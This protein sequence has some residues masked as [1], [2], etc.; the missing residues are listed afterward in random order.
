MGV[1]SSI[2]LLNE[3]A[4][5][6]ASAHARHVN[7]EPEDEAIFWSLTLDYTHTLACRWCRNQHDLDPSEIATETIHHVVR[8]FPGCLALK[9][10]CYSTWLFAVTRNK[11]VDR[12]RSRRGQ[13]VPLDTVR[14]TPAAEPSPEQAAMIRELNDIVASLSSDE[15]T[16]VLQV[17]GDLTVDQALKRLGRARATYFREQRQ[18]LNRLKG[19]LQGGGHANVPSVRHRRHS[20][21]KA[22]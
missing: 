6:L 10:A 13:T 8:Q 18:L 3:I 14:E 16:I 2:S 7:P 1:A 12:V 9:Q 19:R 11:Y 21:D 17:I 15:R 22:K 4:Q 5:R 20:H